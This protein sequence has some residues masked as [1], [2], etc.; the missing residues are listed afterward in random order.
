MLSILY[1]ILFP[2]RL[3]HLFVF[4]GTSD[5]SVPWYKGLIGGPQV[6]LPTIDLHMQL[7]IPSNLH[8]GTLIIG[9]HKHYVVLD[10]SQLSSQLISGGLLEFLN[11]Y[12]AF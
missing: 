5:Q 8:G 4:S 7:A 11:I 2:T 6:N 1:S 9:S 3:P 10:L 12:C